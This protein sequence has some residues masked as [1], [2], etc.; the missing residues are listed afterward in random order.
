MLRRF[1]TITILLSGLVLTGAGCGGGSAATTAPVTLRYWRVFDGE[2]DFA[3]II[4]K[5][6]S[7][8]PNVTIDYRRLRFEE[9]QDELIRAFAEGRG[10]DLFTVQNTEMAGYQS[11]MSPMP[12]QVTISQKEKRNRFSSEMVDVPITKPTIT[13]R[14]LKERFI[15]QVVDN[16]LVS[17]P[18]KDG[19]IDKVYG[20]PLAV[21][22]LV[23]YYNVDLLNA[24]GIPKPPK[25]WDEFQA[26]SIKLTSYDPKGEITQSG[27]AL[28]TANNVERS[29]DILSTI[30]MQVGVKMVDARGRVNFTDKIDDNSRAAALRALE[31]YTQFSNKGREAY[32][33]NDTQSDSLQAF[34]SGKTAFF[35]G[36]AYHTP[37]IRTNAPRLNFGIAG[38]P[39]L[40][41][42]NV[43]KAYFANYWIETVANSSKSKDWAWDFLLFATSDEQAATYIAKAQKPT[44]HKNLIDTQLKDEYLGPF[45]EQVL[46]AKNWYEGKDAATAETAM[47]DLINTFVTG[48]D[49]PERAI[50]NAERKIQ[51]T[52]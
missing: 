9:Y 8:H 40:T 45:V 14:Q 52:Y 23:L 36:Y 24:A 27:A 28:G 3:S 33:W 19:T 48:T 38:F 30:M 50:Q 44:A 46:L 47:R 42:A 6:E 15:D 21:D 29:S 31:F 34:T 16:V 32:S 26:D 4:K 41:G 5:Y 2:D 13:L 25:T 37:V 43:Q 18:T 51:Q 10:P 7:Q 20:L 35:F 11:L 17:T 1:L 22:T 39:Q 49:D 12:D